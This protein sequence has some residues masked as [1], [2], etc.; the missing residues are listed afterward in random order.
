MLKHC[1][2]SR[3]IWL[4]GS[5]PRLE[6]M[7]VEQ[8]LPSLPISGPPASS[9]D[10]RCP[11]ILQ[12]LAALRSNI[13]FAST[14][15]PTPNVPPCVYQLQPS[16]RPSTALRYSRAV[17]VR[18]SPSSADATQKRATCFGQQRA[19]L[20]TAVTHVT[21]ISITTHNTVMF[22]SPFPPARPQRQGKI[23]KPP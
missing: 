19:T 11:P 14:R 16:I 21:G 8:H 13:S 3:G 12:P 15:V 1:L 6:R 10:V 17:A 7:N 18:A 22:S 5:P 2:P 9:S 23:I 20:R 4:E